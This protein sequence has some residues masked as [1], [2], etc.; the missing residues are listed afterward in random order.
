MHSASWKFTERKAKIPCSH[1][2]DPHS[3][4]PT[5]TRKNKISRKEVKFK[6]RFP[7]RGLLYM[8]KENLRCC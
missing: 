2:A 6:G 5:D 3:A 1:L 8:K 7:R 4:S